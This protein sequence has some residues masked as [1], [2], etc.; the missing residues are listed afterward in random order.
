VQLGEERDTDL[1]PPN[2][3]FHAHSPTTARQ[4]GA[5]AVID[6]VTRAARLASLNDLWIPRLPS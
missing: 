5:A 2:G 3:H 4:G 1:L 6:L